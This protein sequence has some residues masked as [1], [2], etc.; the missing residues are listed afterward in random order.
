MRGERS[1]EIERSVDDARRIEPGLLRLP[2]APLLGRLSTVRAARRRDDDVVLF[3]AKMAGKRVTR[4][5][6][7][8][9]EWRGRSG[10]RRAGKSGGAC[11]DESRVEGGFLRT[12]DV[13]LVWILGGSRKS[14]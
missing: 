5:I 9:N 6:R 14:L 4:K 8:N 3:G 12:Q 1:G 13:S 10:E 2:R 11:E 7:I